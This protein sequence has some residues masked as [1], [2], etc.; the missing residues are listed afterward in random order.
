MGSPNVKVAPAPPRVAPAS[1]R[2]AGGTQHTSTGRGAAPAPAQSGERQ[3]KRARDPLLAA[4]QVATRA[5]CKGWE[6]SDAGATPAAGPRAPGQAPPGRKSKGPSAT[7]TVGG[8]SHGSGKGA[9]KGRRGL[10]LLPVHSFFG[11]ATASAA[12]SPTTRPRAIG[13]GHC[14][15]PRCRSWHRGTGA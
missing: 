14:P 6:G 15:S 12:E 11:V 10:G 8:Q 3:G 7:V 13:P 2:E 4:Y 1:A 5:R 9:G